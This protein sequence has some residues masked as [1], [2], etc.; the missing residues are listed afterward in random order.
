[1]SPRAWSIFRL[2]MKD[3][4]GVT[5]VRQLALNLDVSERTIRYDL[6]ALSDFLGAYGIALQR[7]PHKGISI[8]PDDV[9]AAPIAFQAEMLPRAG[10]LPR[11]SSMNPI[12][13][14]LRQGWQRSAPFMESG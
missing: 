7:V 2:L 4:F 12:S 9:A 8:S 6:D 14:L 5:T 11:P 13:R 10:F 1:M 3:P